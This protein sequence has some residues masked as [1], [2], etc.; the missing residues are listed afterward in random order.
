[1]SIKYFFITFLFLFSVS[2]VAQVKDCSKF[3]TGTF[4]NNDDTIIVRN[5][6]LQTEI[7]TKTNY[8]YIAVVKWLSDCQYTLTFKEITDPIGNQMIGITITV[9]ILSTSEDS[10]KYHAH[11]DSFEVKGELT[12]TKNSYKL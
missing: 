10:Y 12:K 8:R 4:K 5:D 3:R 9:D 6:S 1:M 2:S 11:N 7:H